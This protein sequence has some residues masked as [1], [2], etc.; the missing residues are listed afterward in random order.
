MFC[1][2]GEKTE[3]SIEE[4]IEKKKEKK[5]YSKGIKKLYRWKVRKIEMKRQAIV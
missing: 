1:D 5:G 4:K 3:R 2:A